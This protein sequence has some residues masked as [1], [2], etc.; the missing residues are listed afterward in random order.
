MGEVVGESSSEEMG[1][2][3]QQMAC[4][5]RHSWENDGKGRKQQ[6]KLTARF[7]QVRQ[8]GGNI[9]FVAHLTGSYTGLIVH[10]VLVTVE[11]Q[12]SYGV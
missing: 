9:D 7:V 3:A 4:H 10:S 6:S 11:I 8:T 1:G 5:P 2:L 12:A